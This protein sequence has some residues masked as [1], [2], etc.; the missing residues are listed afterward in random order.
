MGNSKAEVGAEDVGVGI[1]NSEAEDGGEDVGVGVGNPEVKIGVDDIVEGDD[2]RETDTDVELE[3]W[4]NFD[5]DSL[6]DSDE[7]DWGC[8]NGWTEGVV[9]VKINVDYGKEKSIKG[10]VSVEIG[11]SEHN[12]DS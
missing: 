12:H 7:Y 1:G 9:D 11:P 5:V 6:R 8:G 2:E 10:L 4:I 3:S